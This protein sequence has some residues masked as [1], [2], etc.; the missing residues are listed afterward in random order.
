MTAKK[1]SEASNGTLLGRRD[2]VTACGLG[3]LAAA[4]V[5]GLGASLATLWPR[6]GVEAGARVVVGRPADYAVGQVDA[7]YLAELGFWVVREATGFFAASARCTHLGCKLRHDPAGKGF[8]CMCHGS[9]FDATGE[10]LRGPAARAMD[11]FRVTLD[12]GGRLV[13]DRSSRLRKGAG[14]WQ[15]GA[16]LRV[17]GSKR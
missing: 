11:R 4:T 6:A 13:V 14:G 7:R 10:V 16:S 12:A 3:A 2:V 1:D 9:I 8:R 15:D 17:G 5:G